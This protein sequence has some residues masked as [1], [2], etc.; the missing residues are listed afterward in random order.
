MQVAPYSLIEAFELKQQF[1]HLVGKTFVDAD[2]SLYKIWFIT[3]VPSD[4]FL[5]VKFIGVVYLAIN[6]VQEYDYENVMKELRSFD[7]D[8]YDIWLL[9]VNN[10]ES[11]SDCKHVPLQLLAK[12][13]ELK[14][15]FNI[16]PFEA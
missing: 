11:G 7:K 6:Q 10:T 8:E 12:E 3:P 16:R 5:Q 15:G 2:G 4:A 1:D 13:K 9:A 14:L